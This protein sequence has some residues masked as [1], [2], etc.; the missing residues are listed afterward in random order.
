MQEC[1]GPSAVL[2]QVRRDRGAFLELVVRGEDASGDQSDS[3]EEEE[4]KSAELVPAGSS[5]NFKES[6]QRQGT[7]LGGALRKQTFDKMAAGEDPM[8]LRPAREN[9]VQRM[10]HH[11]RVATT[12]N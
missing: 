3:G 11:V 2:E 10:A 6:L 12:C 5:A 1:L 8:R 4:L 7:A 9:R